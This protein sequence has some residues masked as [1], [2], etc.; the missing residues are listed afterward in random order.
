MANIEILPEFLSSGSEDEESD[1]PEVEHND[2]DE[3]DSKKPRTDT[4]PP[5]ESASEAIS[6]SSG[7]DYE[8][9]VILMSGSPSS[10]PAE[11]EPAVVSD[12]DL[13][14]SAFMDLVARASG[15]DKTKQAELLQTLNKG[16]VTSKFSTEAKREYQFLKQC[17][18]DMDGIY[19]T[20]V[21]PPTENDMYALGAAVSAARM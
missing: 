11:A 21:E 13:D 1:A 9:D 5:M 10:T 2:H 19:V 15:G 3:R 4:P 12:P 17:C 8:S 14:G 20:E 16:L 6:V 7:S 18:S